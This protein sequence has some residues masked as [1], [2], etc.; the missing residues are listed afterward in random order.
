MMVTI[1]IIIYSLG[2]LSH[3]SVLVVASVVD[4]VVDFSSSLSGAFVVVNDSSSSNSN[5]DIPAAFMAS[6]THCGILRKEENCFFRKSR[7]NCGYVWSIIACRIRV[8][9]LRHSVPIRRT[10]TRAWMLV[11]KGEKDTQQ[12]K[13]TTTYMVN[14][15]PKCL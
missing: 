10:R 3:V 1:T 13:R 6:C 7:Q 14:D 8:P 2:F 15:R 11:Y 9:D 12:S 4:V 5:K